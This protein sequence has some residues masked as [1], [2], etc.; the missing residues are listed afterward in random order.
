MKLPGKNKERGQSLVEFAITLPVLILILSGLLDLGR[1][2]YIYVALEEAVAEAAL[3][4]AISPRCPDDRLSEC[5]DPNNALYRAENASNAEFDIEN[6]SWNIPFDADASTAGWADPE[7]DGCST[8]GCTM[9]VQVEYEF[10]VLTPGIQRFLNNIDN[11][12]VLRT[13]AAQKIVF[14]QR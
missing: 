14:E 11:V 5:A 2:Y 3:Y 13:Q 12:I 8:I 7:V 6:A 10:E 1:A 9:L 4:L